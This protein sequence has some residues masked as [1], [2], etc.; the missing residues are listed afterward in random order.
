[1]ITR[2]GSDSQKL[3]TFANF[4]REMKRF[5]TFG[6]LIGTLMQQF[7]SAEATDIPNLDTYSENL[8]NENAAIEVVGELGAESMK[9]YA[10]R[11]N[12]IMTDFVNLGYYQWSNNY[13]EL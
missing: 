13:G 11:I 4:Q 3:F 5:G 7:I 1:M 2:L 8:K 12:D 6:S 10:K 9:K